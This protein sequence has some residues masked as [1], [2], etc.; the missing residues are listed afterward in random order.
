[1]KKTPEIN[2]NFNLLYSLTE[3][4]SLHD[5]FKKLIRY[6]LSLPS[7]KDRKIDFSKVLLKSTEFSIEQTSQCLECIY[8]IFFSKSSN[9][10]TNFENLLNQ[11]G[12]QVKIKIT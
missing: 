10:N 6:I 11:Q 3:K 4:N 12:F 7:K 1:M 2:E 5:G 9:Y 8:S